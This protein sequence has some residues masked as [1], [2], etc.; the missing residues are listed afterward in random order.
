MPDTITILGI[1]SGSSLDGIDF[2]VCSFTTEGEGAA[3]EVLDWRIEASRTDPYPPPWPTRLRTAP[4]STGREL[5]Q[6]H[7]DL[8]RWIGQRATVFL[9]DHP[10]LT[11]TLA[12]SHGHTVFHE[13]A[14]GFTT[15]LG[16]G[17]ALASALGLPTVTELRSTDVAAGGQG[18]PIAPVAD[19]YLLPGHAAYV[20]LG[21]IANISVRADEQTLV[22]GDV[23]GCCQILDRL[24]EQLGHAYDEGGR[25]AASGTF[26]PD[27]AERIA[28][29]PYHQARYPKSLANDWVRDDL[30][31][32][33]DRADLP[34]A[35]RLHTY[36]TWLAGKI[37]VDIASLLPAADPSAP[38]RSVLIAGGGVNNDYLVRQLNHAGAGA[39]RLRFISPGKQTADFK[40]AALVAL[41]ALLRVRGLPNALPSA[42]GAARPTING[43]L[44]LPPP[45]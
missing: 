33:L 27:L 43:A 40:E 32:L 3:F 10:G 21:G 19:N 1:M 7:T 41:C 44:Y 15:Q 2:A 22:A 4:S 20:N 36:V 24:A 25:L 11:P 17:A 18:A 28:S 30:W 6:L 45:Q 29:L 26:V 37:A 34:A 5:W 16:D 39:D 12:G 23:S 31:P 14:L 8:G 9:N 13:P 35:D 38:L 42:T